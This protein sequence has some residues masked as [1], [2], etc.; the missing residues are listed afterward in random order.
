M[1]WAGEAVVRRLADGDVAACGEFYD[2]YAPLVY[3]LILR[4][5]RNPGVASDVLRGVFWEAWEAAGAYDSR[6]SPEAWIVARARARALARGGEPEVIGLPLQAGHEPFA[7]WTAAYATGALPAGER[8]EL[9]KHMAEGCHACEAAV[10]AHE[11]ALADGA[12]A[13]PALAPPAGV[14]ADLMRRVEANASARGW[15]RRRRRMRWILGTVAAVIGVAAWTAGLVASRYEA[16]VGLLARE[17]ARV[18]ADLR[19][20]EDALRDRAAVA[21]GLIDLLHDPATRALTLRGIGPG[22]S[23]SGRVLWHETQNGHVF[24]ADLP[25]VPA[26]K[27]Y[28]LWTI[29][30]GRPRAAGSLT[31]DAA[32]RGTRS[33]PPIRGPVQGFRVTLESADSPPAPAGPVVLQS[34]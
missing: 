9:E 10:L 21:Q 12:R 16:R 13:A 15:W 23:S 30:D 14:R 26:G 22:A 31:V 34:P 4:S 24:V 1:A 33:L 5:V 29:A 19:R 32:G 8:A 7:R 28:A 18:R 11:E 27:T 20:Q 17:T 2:R 3:P 25:P 6:R